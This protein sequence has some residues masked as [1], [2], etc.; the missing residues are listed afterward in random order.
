MSI[1]ISTDDSEMRILLFNGYFSFSL[2][3]LKSPYSTLSLKKSNK[4]LKLRAYSEICQRLL[5]DLVLRFLEDGLT[6]VSS[7]SNLSNKVHFKKD[8]LKSAKKLTTKLST[9]IGKN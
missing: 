4:F 3:I 6:I 2:F 7:R 5:S 9:V 8:I 1:V